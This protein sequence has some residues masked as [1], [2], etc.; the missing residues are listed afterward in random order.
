M[1]W[2]LDAAATP[3]LATTGTTVTVSH[4]LGGGSNR[5]VIAGGGETGRNVTG[6]TYNGVAMTAVSNPAAGAMEA[7]LFYMLESQLPAAG[8]YNMVLT[9]D[10]TLARGIAHCASFTGVA[11]VAFQSSAGQTYGNVSSISDSVTPTSDAALLVALL[12]V[13]DPRTITPTGGQGTAISIL[14]GTASL[15]RHRL[16]AW[17]GPTPA[18]LTASSFTLSSASTVNAQHVAAFG[19]ASAGN[20]GQQGLQDL[21]RGGAG[22]HVSARLGGLLQG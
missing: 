3:V 4:T 17:S 12:A 20:V 19:I 22:V 15:S 8:T 9:F 16:Y 2:A 1:A 21:S 18:A 14:D 6:A 7:R 11:Q 5:I 13:G 10:G